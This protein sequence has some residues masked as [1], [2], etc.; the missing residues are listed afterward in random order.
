MTFVVRVQDVIDEMDTVSDKCHAYLNRQTGEL[1]TI[2][3]EEISA[4]E[5]AHD[6]AD[7]ADW[8]K[9]LIQKTRQVLDSDDYLPLPTKFDIHEYSIMQRFCEEVED[10]E[11]SNELLF[12]IKGSGAFQRFKH[13]IHRYNITEDWYRHRQESLEQ[14]AIDW[15][16]ANAIPYEVNGD[17]PT[18]AS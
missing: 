18:Q 3:D 5:E 7:Y 13:A 16:E 15:L 12:Q 14:I 11:L 17:R 6:L 4:V 10:A 8:Q 1:V 9:E 2:G